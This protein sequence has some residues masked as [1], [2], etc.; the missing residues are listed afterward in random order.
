MRKYIDCIR[1]CNENLAYI[2]T[3]ALEKNDAYSVDF[4]DH[5]TDPLERR[6]TQREIELRVYRNEV[7]GLVPKMGFEGD[8]TDAN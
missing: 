4:F 3:E 2:I 8:K 6:N 7:V 1:V 5:T